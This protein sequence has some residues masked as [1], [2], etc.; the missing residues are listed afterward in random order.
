MNFRTSTLLGAA[1][2]VFAL[3]SLPSSPAAAVGS[4]KL[5]GPE[6]ETRVEVAQY[7]PTTTSDTFWSIAQKTRPDNS[8]TVYQM[9]AAIFEA[10]PHAFASDNYNSLE[11]GMILAIPSKEVIK[12]IPSSLAKSRA[13]Q[14]DKSWQAMLRQEA[15][16]PTPQQV[17]E[18]ENAVDLK[19]ARQE[20][21]QINESLTQA[22]S[23]NLN[24]TDE[25]GRALDQLVVVKNDND[26]LKAKIQD[27]S[28]RVAT[29]EQELIT[30]REQNQGLRQKVEQL[31][32]EASQAA[33]PKEEQAFITSPLGLGLISVGVTLLLLIGLWIV[34]KRK[35]SQAAQAGATTAA[36]AAGAVAATAAADGLKDDV[37]DLAVHLDEPDDS[38]DSLLDAGNVDLEPETDLSGDGEPDMYVAEEDEPE[39]APEPD[40]SQSL[41]DLWAEAMG[42]Q[43][44]GE[45]QRDDDDVDID[46][47]ESASEPE[48]ELEP[49]DDLAPASDD[50]AAEGD[51]VDSLIADLESDLEPD[52][53]PSDDLMAVES[54]GEPSESEMTDLPTQEG[55]DED[56][57]D[58]LLAGLDVDLP[59]EQEAASEIEPAA[60]DSAQ[61]ALDAELDAAMADMPDVDLPEEEADV[62]ALLAGLDAEPQPESQ[63]EPQAEDQTEFEAEAEP[64]AE[65]DETHDALDAELDA[66]MAEMPDVDLPEEEADVDALLAGLDAEPR[67]EPQPEP[68]AEDQTEFEA[69][70]EPAAEADETQDALDAELDAAM[71]DMPDVD[72]PEEEA[73]VDALLAGLEAEPQAE[74]EMEPESG[75]E[76]VSDAAQHELHSELDDALADIEGLDA[77][78]ADPEALLAGLQ[79]DADVEAVDIDAEVDETEVNQAEG[80]DA[81]H[82]ELDDAL[83]DIEGLDTDDADPEALLAGLQSDTD[84]EVNQAEGID[85]LH[86]ELDDALADIEGLDAEEADPEALLAGLQSDE[87]VEVSTPEAA[88]VAIDESNSKLDEELD[89][90]LADIGGLNTEDADPEALLAGLQSDSEDEVEPQEAVAEDAGSNLDMDTPETDIQQADS[91]ETDLQEAEAQA[92]ETQSEETQSEET[93]SEETVDTP[94][95]APEVIDEQDSEL[96][97]ELDSALADIDGLNTEDADPEALLA[98]LQSDSED[99]VEEHAQAQVVEDA[100][101]DLDSLEADIQQADIQETD[102]QEAETE[103]EETVDTPDAAVETIEEQ[104]SELDEELDSALADIDG[105]N[106]EDADPEALLAGLQSGADAETFVPDTEEADL[107]SLEADIQESEGRESEDLELATAEEVS[108]SE[109]V[110]E[111]DDPL[112]ELASLE[113]R[114]STADFGAEEFGSELGDGLDDDFLTDL[115]SSEGTTFSADDLDSLDEN[116]Q[117]IQR[118]VNPSVVPDMN[119][120]ELTNMTALE[121]SEKAMDEAMS[122]SELRAKHREEALARARQAEAEEADVSPDELAEM[123]SMAPSQAAAS[124]ASPD[125]FGADLSLDAH[126]TDMSLSD[127]ELLAAFAENEEFSGES[128]DSIGDV[129]DIEVDEQALESTN[130]MTVE[131]ALAALDAKEQEQATQQRPRTAHFDEADLANFQK[132]NG[133]IDIDRLLNE[134]DESDEVDNY[135]GPAEVAMEDY[136]KVVGDNTMV[137]VDDEENSVN[138]KLDLARAYIEI[139][140][141]DSARA[142][143]QEVTLDGNDRQ[144]DEAKRLLE[145]IG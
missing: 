83:A 91:Q 26:N 90:A 102:L 19:E 66:A 37:D 12:A 80:T 62:D 138:A 103:A 100:G 20:L 42:E 40:E 84:A 135:Q 144:Q 8:V 101:I 114:D 29:L 54:A 140:D 59:P 142:L 15:A 129:A 81:L 127:E 32:W 107:D 74:P 123:A 145:K 105:L 46:N 108:E 70:A 1:T 58:A 28:D 85:E 122:R 137:D 96:H 14:D 2:V 95:A 93:Q 82:S 27:L 117:P 121:R 6:G 56:D 16:K 71:A 72:L 4:L 97:Q 130:N 131:Q 88:P 112:A 124:Q 94:E 119:Q 87:D 50:V 86:S 125:P 141:N 22:Q 55:T 132:E 36:V 61:D 51:D 98:G 18:A 73:D 92:E 30:S 41:D 47:I 76:P 31:E 136:R 139:D 60:E 57:V 67:P 25:L 69:E 53:A 65:T 89:S 7:G 115:D 34:L 106:T 118:G 45:A 3:A 52:I 63:P 68:Q 110:A 35:S 17:V 48:G 21:D 99:E 120:G 33:L 143:L 13:E 77:G 116:G 64:A 11:K 109:S 104:D 111:A 23:K 10:N 38:I 78:D 39:P 43:E 126:D 9:M 49:D 134:A 44:E 113:S 24:L 128:A 133:F 79:S 75:Q 5:T